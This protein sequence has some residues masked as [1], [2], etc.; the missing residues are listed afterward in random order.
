MLFVLLGPD[1]F[2]FLDAKERIQRKI[3]FR[4]Q[5]SAQAFPTRVPETGSIEP[6]R[7]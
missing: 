5:L 2:F 7:G 4:A 6:L 1:P 3:K